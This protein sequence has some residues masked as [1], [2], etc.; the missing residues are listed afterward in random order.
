MSFYNNPGK[1]DESIYV[2][3]LENKNQG[4]SSEAFI[5]L[6]SESKEFT[7]PFFENNSKKVDWNQLVDE[8][9]R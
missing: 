9:F 6:G 4:H 8:V 3:E 1:V 2:F 5:S 7:M